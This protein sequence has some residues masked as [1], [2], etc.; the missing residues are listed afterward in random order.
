MTTTRKPSTRADDKPFDFNLD[1]VEAESDLSPFR[2]HYAGRRWEFAHF[3]SLDTWDSLE[4]ADGGDVEAIVGLMRLGLGGQW[5]EFRKLPLPQ[6][7]LR[8]LF[9][10]W[11]EHCGHT[12][13]ESP[14]SDDS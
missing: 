2:V 4:A 11:S 6:Y 12:A 13:G 10:Q 14:A 5:E 1:A 8:P 7:K 3:E 9:E